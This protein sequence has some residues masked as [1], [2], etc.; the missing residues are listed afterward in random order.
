MHVRVM[1]N[2]GVKRENEE[3]IDKEYRRGWRTDR[4]RKR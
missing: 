2:E 4:D 3:N 1:Q